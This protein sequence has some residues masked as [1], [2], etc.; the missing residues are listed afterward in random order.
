MT[1]SV[2][3]NHKQ[4]VRTLI[5]NDY[6]QFMRTKNHLNDNDRYIRHLH[7]KTSKFLRENPDIYI[8]NSDKGQKTVILT[9]EMYETKMLE[10]LDDKE[11]YVLIPNPSSKINDMMRR[12]NN[13]LIEDLYLKGQLTVTSCIPP[14]IYGTFKTHKPNLPVRPVMSTVN[15]AT[16]PV[17]DKLQAIFSQLPS[18]SMD[19]KYSDIFKEKIKDTVLTNSDE[20]LSLDVVALYTN[21][22][23][24][25]AVESCM[26][27]WDQIRT[28]T[29]LKKD[30]F[31]RLLEM[32]IFESN[33]FL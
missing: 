11:T 13:N 14:R 17:C 21:I 8:V 1:L 24:K 12:R 9:K 7:N 31:R 26:K 18:D 6:V 33:F 2:H 29:I 3:H 10:H 25:D 19:V 23:Q 30:S 28:H 15:T 22:N 32:C 16:R 5:T 27:R 20:C 4:L